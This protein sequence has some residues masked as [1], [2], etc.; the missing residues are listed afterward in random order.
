M[1]SFNIAVPKVK[2][3]VVSLKLGEARQDKSLMASLMA[4]LAAI[5]GQRPKIC[6]AKKAIASFKLQAGDQVGLVVTLR[7]KRMADFLEKL[8]KIVLPRVRDFRGVKSSGFDGRGNYSLGLN[9]YL[10]FSEIDYDKVRPI[11]GLEVTLVTTA[12]DDNQ[13]RELLERLGMPFE[14]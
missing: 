14:K 2:K 10:V 6:R 5:T 7:G 8:F 3:V 4:D 1:S 9:E 13:G 12:K 11:R